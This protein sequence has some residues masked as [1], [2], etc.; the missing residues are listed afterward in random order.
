MSWQCK[1]PILLRFGFAFLNFFHGNII[2]HHVFLESNA[3]VFVGISWPYPYTLAAFQ[4]KKDKCPR[5]GTG[6]L[7][8]D[9][10]ITSYVY[11]CCI[12][13]KTDGLFAWVQACECYFLAKRRG[14]NVASLN[15]VCF[16][17]GCGGWYRWSSFFSFLWSGILHHRGNFSDSWW[18]TIKTLKELTIKRSRFIWSIKF[19]QTSLL[20]R[21]FKR[22]YSYLSAHGSPSCLWN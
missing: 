9:V 15:L 5:R 6:T 21:W 16:Q 4:R 3:S 13:F 1:P 11:Q 10:V 7:W 19:C 12:F 17:V 2:S 22:C 14:K 20:C 18:S 8:F